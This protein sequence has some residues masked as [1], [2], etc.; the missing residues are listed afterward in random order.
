MK[1]NMMLTDKI[2][3]FFEAASKMYAPLVT[4]GGLGGTGGRSRASTP[5]SST[6]QT[7]RSTTQYW[8]LPSWALESTSQLYILL[9]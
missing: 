7:G 8:Y 4:S 6:V 5:S 2:K 1:M 3:P 9:L